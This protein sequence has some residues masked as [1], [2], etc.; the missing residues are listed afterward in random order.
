MF[1]GGEGNVC[2]RRLMR[3]LAAGPAWS[4][5]LDGVGAAFGCACEVA[6]PGPVS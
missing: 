2:C 1:A 3:D 4:A 6:L 5:A